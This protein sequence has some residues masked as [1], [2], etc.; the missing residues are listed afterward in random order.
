MTVFLLLLVIPIVISHTILTVPDIFLIG[1]AKCGSTSFYDLLLQSPSI[2]RTEKEFQFFNHEHSPNEY[3][4][5]AN[6]FSNCSNKLTL[7]ASPG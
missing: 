5:Y 3:Q 4:E 2:C 7:D 1:C 6:E